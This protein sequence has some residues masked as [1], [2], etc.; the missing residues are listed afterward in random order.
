[1]TENTYNPDAENTK[2]EFYKWLS[3]RK[4]ILDPETVELIDKFYDIGPG[5]GKFYIIR[6]LA[7]FDLKVYNDCR[8]GIAE[9]YGDVAGELPIAD[10]EEDDNG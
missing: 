8:L 4:E 5:K 3:V 10:D 7:E 1:M 9:T 2:D 6:A